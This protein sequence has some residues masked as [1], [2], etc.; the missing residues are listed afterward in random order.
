MATTTITHEY[1]VGQ[2]VWFMLPGNGR[3]VLTN[4]E[5]SEIRPMILKEDKV[6]VR[7]SVDFIDPAG[8]RLNATLW[9]DEVF[10]NKTRAHAALRP[11]AAYRRV[12]II[13]RENYTGADED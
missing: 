10:P 8:E 11:L 13:V 12:D 4:G 7:Y 5:I 6:Y 2:R 1:Y 9:E 3:I